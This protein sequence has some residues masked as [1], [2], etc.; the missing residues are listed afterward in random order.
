M[1]MSKTKRNHYNPRNY[2]RAWSANDAQIYQLDLR[3]DKP[4]P[5]FV[6]V[7]DAGIEKFLYP[8]EVEDYLRDCVEGPAWGVLNKLRRGEQV[9]LVELEP[10]YIYVAA[11][12]G[13]TPAMRDAL[14]NRLDVVRGKVHQEWARHG[15]GFAQDESDD[16]LIVDAL[17][18]AIDRA[19]T[20]QS[21]KIVQVM[22]RM[23][24]KVYQLEDSEECITSD[25]GVYRIGEKLDDWDAGIFFPVSPNRV[26]VGL[27]NPDERWK[28]T[29]GILVP[30]SAVEVQKAFDGYAAQANSMIVKHAN[31]FIFGKSEEGLVAAAR[32][33]G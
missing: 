10:L 31:R 3:A 22:R 19:T 29:N 4:E 11:Q 17:E 1:K 5:T 25:C 14:R 12:I 15:M 26:L 8:Q 32:S 28:M 23:M 13:R 7:G 16:Q 2:L 33:Y 20:G 27:G 9:L 30:K 6:G 21:P 18:H 24:W